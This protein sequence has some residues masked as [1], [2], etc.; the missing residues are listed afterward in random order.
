MA[1]NPTFPRTQMI[2]IFVY[3]GFEPLD[4]FGFV[5]PFAIARFLGTGYTTTSAGRR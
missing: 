5:Q 2:G 4:V 1:N 3:E